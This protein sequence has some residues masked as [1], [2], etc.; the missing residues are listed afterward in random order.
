MKVLRV[1]LLS[2][3]VLRAMSTVEAGPRSDV[4]IEPATQAPVSILKKT[5]RSA[6]GA[7]AGTVASENAVPIA[8]AWVSA[9]GSAESMLTGADGKYRLE[10]LPAGDIAIVV[11]ASGFESMV[12]RVVISLSRPAVLDFR[13]AVKRRSETVEVSGEIPLLTTGKELGVVRL[14]PR[15]I[16]TLPSLGERD[17]F[18]TMQLLPGVSGTNETSS[19]LYVRGGTPSQTLVAY[20]GFTV[21]HVDHLFGYYSA[22]NMD[23]LE[24]VELRKGAYEARFGGRLSAVME[25]HGRSGPTDRWSGSVTASMLSVSTSLS[26]PVSD[27]G[28]LL[29]AGRRS[30][31]S[32]L[33]NNILDLFGTNGS[34]AANG[35]GLGGGAR[36]RGGPG[37]GFGADTTPRSHFY[38]LNGRF[39]MPFGQRDRLVVS[40]YAGRDDL[41][42]SVAF[43]IPEFNGTLPGGV[44]APPF[45]ISG[46]I[47]TSDIS[48]W[49]NRGASITWTRGW[50]ARQQT[51]F[52][53][54]G[55]RYD[56][57]TDRQ[58]NG[59]ITITG[60]T[61]GFPTPSA[62]G[63]SNAQYESNRLDDVSLQ[64]EHS[65]ALGLSHRVVIGGRYTN[66]KVAYRF[67]T[68]LPGAGVDLPDGG[69]RP[70]DLN[71][72]LNRSDSGALMSGYVQDEARLGR[73]TV[74]PGL[75]V[76]SFDRTAETYVEPRASLGIKITEPLR[77]KGGWGKYTQVVNRIEREDFSN[78][79]QE[80]WTLSDG[81]T[82]PAA[83]ATHYVGGLTFEKDAL[84]VDAEIFYKSL[85]D[86]TTFAPRLRPGGNAGEAGQAFYQG[87]GTARGL[88]LLIQKKV[89]RHSG[90][91][92]Y[93]L[94]KTEETFP[95]LEAENYPS[96]QDQRHELK[97]VDTAKFGGWTASGTWILATGKP[98]TA[99]TGVSTITI[100][101]GSRT[102]GFPDFG[103][104]NGARL[105]AY[106]RLD[107]AINRE[108]RIWSARGTVGM[109]VFNVYDRQNVWYK[110]FQGFSSQ[111]VETDVRLMGRAFNVSVG[112]RF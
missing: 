13:L 101:D 87:S 40:T 97:L 9:V 47:D 92:S 112:L 84:L 63:L 44:T 59:Q 78:G 109:T 25:L 81:A 79:N 34:G 48:N 65:A 95:T 102:V 38:D 103:P 110:Q 85:D 72:L 17:I 89:G 69:F 75:R 10:H 76:A 82:V 86:L 24:D 6:D 12:Q 36:P 18:R 22:F 88:E 93:T 4:F 94:S 50:S 91:I 80:F 33:Y 52:I 35:G 16:A 43:T 30:F 32:P 98:Y 29:I 56:K 107:L 39:S 7:A 27:R 45:R 111:L 66:N 62:G 49:T 96:S 70:T 8:G 19:G 31:Q 2:L 11:S 67:D 41:D 73:L 83:R 23:A 61:S 100:G 74:T 37:G 99:A 105:P 20:D 68:Q 108:W 42:N 53:A 57:L 60:N 15:Q 3:A 90:W 26:M 28:S 46:S 1:A 106:H 54:A 64:V 58:S 21:Y 71:Q 5:E 77:L 104:K 14:E 55:S 51:K